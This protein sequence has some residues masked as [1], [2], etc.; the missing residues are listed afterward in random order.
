MVFVHWNGLNE[1]VGPK[2]VLQDL[3][4][5]WSLSQ[6][7]FFILI[8][9]QLV[10][11]KSALLVPEDMIFHVCHWYCYTCTD[12]LQRHIFSIMSA[13]NLNQ[14][15]SIIISCKNSKIS[16]QSV[17]YFSIKMQDLSHRKFHCGHDRWSSVQRRG[18][19]CGIGPIWLHN[20]EALKPWFLAWT[21]VHINQL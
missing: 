3:D 9:I 17:A 1:A 6:P 21:L 4:F 8:L 18:I 14:V 15:F 2:D 19:L 16:W 20:Q 13:F 12:V 11:I 5:K 7:V 10:L